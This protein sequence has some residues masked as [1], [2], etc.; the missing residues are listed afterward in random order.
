M[1]FRMIAIYMVL[2]AACS[3]AT[4]T[5]VTLA[6]AECVSHRTALQL[7]CVDT[8]HD[9]AAID[10]CRAAVVAKIDCVADAGGE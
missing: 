6:G 9:K 7:A 5:P 8:Y 3:P 4:P 1:T 2:L 10:A